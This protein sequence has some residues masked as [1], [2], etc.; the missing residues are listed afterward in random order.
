M[1][2]C[3]PHAKFTSISFRYF[4]TFDCIGLFPLNIFF[5][6]WIALVYF[7]ETSLL[8]RPLKN[9]YITLKIPYGTSILHQNVKTLP[10]AMESLSFGGHRLKLLY[11]VAKTEKS[12]ESL[13]SSGSENSNATNVAVEASV[14]TPV[15]G[16]SVEY[17]KSGQHSNSHKNSDDEG[18]T[19]FSSQDCS[20]D[21][22]QSCIDLVPSMDSFELLCYIIKDKY[23]RDE[24]VKVWID[25]Q[26][27]IITYVKEFANP[28]L[29]MINDNFV[30]M[31]SLDLIDYLNLHVQNPF[32]YEDIE[33]SVVVM[34]KLRE[35]NKLMSQ[36]MALELVLADTIKI[37]VQQFKLR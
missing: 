34:N 10:G 29:E 8:G 25:V 24:C 32:T 12:I 22:S 30:N 5:L 11:Q 17:S 6:H 16:G 4:F 21:N 20:E 35:R 28:I 13:K 2:F 18:S 27:P 19:E 7:T 26:L 33:A 37:F 14:N 31:V 1:T 23:V 9:L 3:D 15:V 36:S